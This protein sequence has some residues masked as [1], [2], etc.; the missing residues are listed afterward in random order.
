MEQVTSATRSKSSFYL[1]V[2][3]NYSFACHSHSFYFQLDCRLCKLV[4]D[5][6]Q[7][8]ELTVYTVV[9]QFNHPI[10]LVGSI[11]CYLYITITKLYICHKMS[12]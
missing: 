4:D 10:F 2:Q 8:L 3:E 5:C 1:L 6:L 12:G 11:R 7:E 9:C